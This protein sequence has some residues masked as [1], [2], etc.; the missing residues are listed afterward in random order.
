M[1][2]GKMVAAKVQSV[3]KVLSP[4]SNECGGTEQLPAASGR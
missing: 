2:A 1:A 4:D 3:R